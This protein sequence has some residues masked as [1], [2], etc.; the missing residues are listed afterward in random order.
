LAKQSF[1]TVALEQVS[2]SAGKGWYV[3]FADVFATGFLP[4]LG[5][6]SA[7]GFPSELAQECLASIG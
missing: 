3:S 6:V 7:A 4:G 1:L 2:A 5:A